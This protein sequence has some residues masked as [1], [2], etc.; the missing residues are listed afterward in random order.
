[1]T[2]E[3]RPGD[4][5][6]PELDDE[7]VAVADRGRPGLRRLVR[8]YAANKAAVL[9][10]VILLVLVVIAL[11]PG[12]FAPADP[13][14]QNL[15]NR[16]DPGPGVLGGDELGRD[17]LSRLIYGTRV[18]LG[19]AAIAVGVSAGFGIPLGIVAGYFRGMTDAVLSRVSEALQSVPALI[20]A[21]TIIAVLGPGLVNAMV[22]VGVV[23]IPHYFRVSRSVAID[24]AGNTYIEAARALGC[25]S[26]RVMWRH[27]LPN[28]VAPLAVQVA[29]TFGAAVTAEASLSFLGLGVQIPTPSWG[30]MLSEGARNMSQAPH[31]VYAPGAAIVL[32]VL[33]F[34]FIGDGLRQAF[35]T[36]Q[37]PGAG[38]EGAR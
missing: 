19:A 36:R 25:S 2:A 12:L 1:M 17:V 29:L 30:S 15:L 31:L 35:G 23:T 6:E 21:L 33:S 34:M 20:F 38:T 8:R 26:T 18:S 11:F 7:G 13:K 4:T 9:G 5:I 10:L 28:T 32:T 16:Y 27:L 24:V 3:T 37:I 14:E 22:A